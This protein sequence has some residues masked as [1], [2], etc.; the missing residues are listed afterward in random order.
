MDDEEDEECP[1]CQGDPS[2]TTCELP[3][4]V[5]VDSCAVAPSGTTNAPVNFATGEVTVDAVDVSVA[6][7]PFRMLRSYS[8]RLSGDFIGPLGN[9]WLSPTVPYLA[10]SSTGRIVFVRGKQ[11]VWFEKIGTDFHCLFGQENTFSL[12]SVGGGELVLAIQT[13]RGQEAYRFY[14]LVPDD[15]RSG[16]MIEHLSPYGRLTTVVAY[17]RYWPAELQCQQAGR[18]WSLLFDF[19]VDDRVDC[20]R[21][22]F[23]TDSGTSWTPLRRACYE[24][25]SRFNLKLVIEQAHDATW[26]DVAKTHYRWYAEDEPGGFLGALKFVIGPQAFAEMETDGLDPLTADDEELLR[27]ADQYLE[28]DE[29]HKVIKEIAQNCAGCGGGGGTGSQG[30]QFE[31]SESSHADAWN[32][33]KFKTVVTRANGNIETVYTNY[34]A[35]VLLKELR[36][37]AV[38][39][40]KWLQYWRYGTDAHNQGQVVLTADPAAVVSFN[41]AAADLNVALAA[42]QGML[43][44]FT[45]GSTTT[46]YRETLG[47]VRGLLKITEI[48]HGTAGAFIRQQELLY[49][50]SDDPGET[51]KVCGRETKYRQENAT[52]PVVT[53]YDYLWYT[54]PQVAIKQLVKRLPPV[55]TAQNGDNTP[56]TIRRFFDPNGSLIFLQDERGIVTK[57]TF[58]A[59]TR[60]WTKRQ[61]DVDG[62]EPGLPSGWTVGGTSPH[63]NATTD[64]AYDALSRPAQ[65][66]GPVHEAVVANA[67][68]L[69][70]KAEW[71]VYKDSATGNQIW[72]AQGFQIVSTGAFVLVDPVSITFSD[73]AGHVTDII[74]SR[75]SSGSGKLSPNDTFLR[76]DWT[77]WS[78]RF[79]NLQGKPTAN[80]TYHTIP[81]QSPDLGLAGVTSAPGTLHTHYEESHRGYDPQTNL[82]IR[83]ISEDGTITRTVYDAINRPTETWIGTD[84]VPSGDTWQ[85]WSPTNNAGTNLVKLSQATYDDGQSG[86]L[87]L[88]SQIEAWVDQATTRVTRFSYDF[89][90]R[91]RLTIAPE[92][93]CT[94]L[95]LNNLGEVVETTGHDG[96]SS[97]S[98]PVPGT[99][100]EKSQSFTDNRGQV[101]QTKT[102]AVDP[103]TGSVGP[104]LT[105]NRWYDPAGS[106]MKSIGE[107]DGDVYTRYERDNLGRDTVSLRG[108]AA[109]AAPGGEVVVSRTE[110]VYDAVDNALLAITRERD[111]DSPITSPTFRASFLAHWYDGASRLIASG[112]YGTNGGTPFTRPATVP[113]RSD[114]VLLTTVA[115]NSA[116]EAFSTTDPAGMETRQIADA[117]GRTTDKIENYQASGSGAD[118]NVTTELIYTPDSQIKT[119]T[120]K[121]PGVGNDQ[122]THYIFG[123]SPATGSYLTV[124]NLLLATQYPED[125]PT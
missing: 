104:A 67:A 49:K 7:S 12:E 125:T 25:D 20:A 83:R 60:R 106:L 72:H 116:G 3:P 38:S 44:H 52:E 56:A 54:S 16:L 107:G 2:S 108:C 111:I 27:Y 112:D 77:R 121:M 88:V 102:F 48:Q 19:D 32:H 43:T 109:A 28:Y 84:D 122:V 59:A 81:P 31:R 73:L 9:N 39:P 80:R 103:S 11:R 46:A 17:D 78:V 96:A 8:N 90:S 95:V 5:N 53:E 42:N 10:Q 33:W 89:R 62:S 45:Y 70:R 115:Y 113:S 26:T 22:R 114:Q 76:A 86:G 97:A 71:I 58:D 87:S 69:V 29:D 74:Q 18:L 13:S 23:S 119:L 94:Q 65:T 47:D 110:T 37:S 51:V 15:P 120:A 6:G 55:T 41:D 30:E 118:V 85:N 82:E 40:R 98:P 117:M 68:I 93:Q 124:N 92:R 50:T 66:L 123:V 64:F 61:V 63:L 105:G 4:R 36:E 35:Q 24:Y 101:Y 91:L 34:L 57:N 1:S 79:Y 14:D 21:L 75:R 99:L 100:I